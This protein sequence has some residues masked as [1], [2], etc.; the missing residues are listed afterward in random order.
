VLEKS[1]ADEA[2]GIDGEAQASR[3]LES[4]VEIG[5]T[6]VATLRRKRGA[7]RDPN[8]IDD[9][10]HRTDVERRDR[11]C[12]NDDA[13]VVDAERNVDSLKRDCA[14]NRERDGQ[15][16]LETG[17][18]VQRQAGL[19]RVRQAEIECG[20]QSIGGQNRLEKAVTVTGCDNERA[21]GDAR[22]KRDRCNG[23]R[24]IDR[25]REL[26]SAELQSRAGR[27]AKH[28]RRC[29]GRERDDRGAEAPRDARR[30]HAGEERCSV[31]AEGEG[32]HIGGERCLEQPLTD[33]L[34]ERQRAERA[35]HESEV[36]TVRGGE[37]DDETRFDAITDQR[38]W[39]A[40]LKG[41]VHVR[42]CVAEHRQVFVR[43]SVTPDD[44]QLGQHRSDSRE[45]RVG[46]CICIGDRREVARQ[47]REAQRPRRIT[48]QRGQSIEPNARIRK[49]RAHDLAV[50]RDARHEGSL[51]HRLDQRKQRAKSIEQRML[52]AHV[53]AREQRDDVASEA[54]ER[55]RPGVAE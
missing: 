6:Y 25:D 1:S 10:A 9:S 48:D 16:R 50:D 18:P 23:A 55:R 42:R 19:G 43:N 32:L 8:A 39:H 49:R 28:Q 21:R 31:T 44:A 33:L 3:R 26:C 24:H 30:V 29:A 34:R 12:F 5:K 36:T 38:R 45:Q 7:R 35:Q 27:R 2:G 15:R 51:V 53:V 37:C 13:R 40:E 20:A 22:R 17:A 47:V 4:E 52:D 14:R 11:R 46:R 41:M 54:T